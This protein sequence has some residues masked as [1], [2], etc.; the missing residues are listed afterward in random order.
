MYKN[1]PRFIIAKFNSV[2]EETGKQIKKGD[3]CLYYPLGKSVYHMDSKQVKSWQSQKQADDFGLADA[4][5]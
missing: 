4:G 1:D 2:C 5:W 3:R